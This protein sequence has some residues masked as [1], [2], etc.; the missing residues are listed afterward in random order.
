MTLGA[1][2]ASI[3]PARH[4]LW[5]RLTRKI[6]EVGL[7]YTALLVIRKLLPPTLLGFT[8]MVILELIPKATVPGA[9]DEAI[10]WA[11]LADSRALGALGHPVEVLEQR[12]RAGARVC[13]L[14]ENESIL[15]YVWF[16]RPYHDEGDL[17]VRFALSAGELWL[18]DAMV[19]A[20]QR[21]RGLY[22][23]LLKGAASDL[24]REG[25]RRI[26]IAVDIA[27][28]NSLRAHG[29]VGAEPV[30]VVSSLRVLGF[31]F[32]RDPSGLRLAWTGRSGYVALTTSRIT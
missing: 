14:A 22:P 8:R 9:V 31:T 5:S 19:R 3:A 15:A 28:R 13:V 32:V 16:H 7:H 29:A 11:G 6:Q 12:F 20:D 26:L 17:G 4:R 21:G 10:R 23:T 24:G 2:R 1:P 25:V 27:N 30:G 18:F